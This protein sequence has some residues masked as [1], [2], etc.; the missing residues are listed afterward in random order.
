MRLNLERPIAFLD[1]EATG[2]NARNERIIDLAVIRIHPD[3]RRDEHY[4]RVNPEKPI[5]ADATAV[6]GITDKDVEGKP[7]FKAVAVAIAAVLKD[8]DLGGFGIVRFDVPLL[9]AEFIRAGIEF[10][11]KDRRL[12]DALAIFHRKEP[13]DLRAAVKFYLKEDFPNAHKAVDDTAAS[14]RVF[15]AQLSRYPDLPTDVM[16]LDLLCNPKDPNWVDETG[17]LV[18]T[19]DGEA[20]INFGKYAGKTLR[21]FARENPSYFDWILSKDFPADVVAIIREAKAGRFPV[22]TPAVSNGEMSP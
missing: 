22:R 1:I 21:S 8:C 15:E 10:S 2:V 11:V 3:G 9:V 14:L 18:W 5:P 16:T 4:W 19:Q 20:A 12:V 6:H 13:R 7:S 17:K